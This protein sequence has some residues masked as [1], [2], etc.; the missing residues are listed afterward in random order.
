M[1]AKES[2]WPGLLETFGDTHNPEGVEVRN[3]IIHAIFDDTCPI[4][5]RSTVERARENARMARELVSPEMWRVLT[6]MHA[7]LA[8]PDIVQDDDAWDELLNELTMDSLLVQGLMQSTILHDEAYYFIQA[9]TALER[10]LS[11]LLLLT[12]YLDS[13]D[14]W[15]HEPLFAVNMLKSVT[16]YGA[17]R[18]SYR[19]RLSVPDVL[20]FLI[21]EQAF[22][23]SLAGASYSLQA[24]TEALPQPGGPVKS[25]IGLLTAQI[26]YDTIDVVMETSPLRYFSEMVEQFKKIHEDLSARY[27]QPEVQE[28]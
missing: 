7:L 25:R 21:F 24:A 10:A 16:G 17:F 13:L 12:S 15:A 6:R 5:L 4:S 20:E 8:N 28:V 1:L 11:T 19:M 22:P 27:F 14:A 18:R 2:N 23:R 3:L 26:S 9:G